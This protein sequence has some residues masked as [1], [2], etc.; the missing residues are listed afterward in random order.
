M[1]HRRTFLSWLSVFS[2]QALCGATGRGE[3]KKPDSKPPASNKKDDKKGD[4]DKEKDKEKGQEIDAALK[5]LIDAL[6]APDGAQRLA[7]TKQLFAKGRAILADLKKAGARQIAPTGPIATRRLDMVY[8]LMEG[9]PVPAPGAKKGYRTNSFGLHL[10]IGTSESE[11]RKMGTRHG[12]TLVGAFTPG[13]R[14]SCYV[15]L[16][17]GKT[18]AEVLKKVLTEEA[19][20]VTVN[21]NYFES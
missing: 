13:A 1:I 2:G 10:P 4:T 18:L 12:F 5:M 11:V 6:E 8:S 14:P 20:V 3:D 21:L 19:S 9:L 15:A 16:M 7:A 17:S